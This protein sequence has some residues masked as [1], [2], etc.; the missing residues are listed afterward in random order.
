MTDL[1]RAANAGGRSVSVHL[2]SV[3]FKTLMSFNPFYEQPMT[4]FWVAAD[5]LRDMYD[6]GNGHIVQRIRRAFGFDVELEPSGCLVVSDAFRKPGNVVLHF[7]PGAHV[8]WQKQNIH[9]RARE[10][11]PES[12][13]VLQDFIRSRPGMHFMEVGKRFSGLDGVENFTRQPLDL[14][15]RRMA[16]CEYFVGIV[17]G[18]LHIAAALGLRCIAVIN[19]PA[20][21]EICLPTLKD[22]DQVESEWFYPQATLLHQDAGSDMVPL[23]SSHTLAAAFDGEVYPY[24]SARYLPLIHEHL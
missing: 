16:E 21:S 5:A 24:W 1:P 11:Y 13:A 10:V 23:F 18:P 4:P 12:L 7:E 14:T 6:L 19:F 9:P 17:S 8:A 3:H 2:P 20:A 22:L 15:I